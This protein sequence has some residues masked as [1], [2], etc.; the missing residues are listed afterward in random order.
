MRHGYFYGRSPE[1]RTTE[2]AQRVLVALMNNARD[3]DIVR[4]RGWYR[5]PVRSAPGPIKFGWLAFYQTKEFKEEG[6]AINYWAEVT[7]SEIVKRRDLL[8]DEAHHPRAEEEYYKIRIGELRCV[9]QPIVSRRQ[10]FIVFIS[11]TLAR[12]QQ[13]EEINDL[14]HE[15]PLEDEVWNGFKQER[16]EAER[17]WYLKVGRATYCLDFAIFCD[18]GQVDVECDGDTWHSDPARI[19]AD[20]ARDNAL[21]SGGWA[22]LRFNTTQITEDLPTC[23][24]HVRETANHYGGIVTAEGERHW[25][26]T[27][28][29]GNKQL[30]L[31]Q[32]AKP[33]YSAGEE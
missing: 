12:F 1:Y 17:Q 26:A 2:P 9:P 20:N 11:T 23:L 19:P 22:V 24:W 16:I 6:W 29:E 27:G 13:A 18:H 8:T 33:E 30:S 15:S 4:K 31:F 28:E 7:G 25:L 3:W 14:F 32:E 5:I 21:T 10:R